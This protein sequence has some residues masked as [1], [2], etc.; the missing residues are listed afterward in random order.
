MS[1]EECSS[2]VQLDSAALGT[3]GSGKSDEASRVDVAGS[4][5]KKG[6]K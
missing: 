5:E 2:D 4:P 6:L 3:V 1:G